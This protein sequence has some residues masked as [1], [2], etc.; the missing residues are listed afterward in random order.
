MVTTRA[1]RAKVSKVSAKDKK[2][3]REEKNKKLDSLVG[4]CDDG[5]TIDVPSSFMQFVTLIYGESASGKTSTCAK[6][7]GSYTIQCDVNRR[8]LK[9]RQTNI[10]STSLEKLQANLS[11]PSPWEVIVRTIELVCEDDSVETVIIDNF[12]LYCEHASNHYCKQ[13]AVDNLS[14]MNDFGTS[15]NNVDSMFLDQLSNIVNAGKGIILIAHQKEIEETLPDGSTIKQV[16]PDVSGRPFQAIRSITDFAFYLGFN[17][18]GGRELTLRYP[19]TDIWTKCCTDESEP[20]F[21]DP[22]GNPVRKIKC[23]DSPQQ[24]WDN[25]MKSWNNELFDA[26]YRE[27]KPL[28]KKIRK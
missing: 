12:R 21:F 19:G 2:A 4:Y 14:E 23:G 8:G 25:L 9:I 3:A 26:D 7:P 15:W 16:R 13:N 27:A 28:K 10:P 6:A 17:G 11:E 22:K 5:E 24:A 1:P 18:E 20:R